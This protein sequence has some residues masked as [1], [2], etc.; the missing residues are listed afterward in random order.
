MMAAASTHRLLVMRENIDW[1]ASENAWIAA[2][3]PLPG[4]A[5]YCH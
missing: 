4:S 5:V 3:W 2:K 1:T